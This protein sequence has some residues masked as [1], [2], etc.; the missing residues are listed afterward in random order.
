MVI[1]CE[2]IQGHADLSIPLAYKI[3]NIF[4]LDARA[5]LVAPLDE[6]IVESQCRHQAARP[7][8]IGT[9]SR[10]E[11]GGLDEDFLSRIDCD[12]RRLVRECK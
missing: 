2:V 9:R 11:T 3:A 1:L 7:W 5:M 6:K 12:G 4:K 8:R 10:L